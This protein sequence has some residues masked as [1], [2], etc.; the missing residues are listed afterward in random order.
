MRQNGAISVS[1]TA[2]QY[3]SACLLPPVGFKW[4][5]ELFCSFRSGE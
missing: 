5:W 4:L 2:Q 1:I 3:F